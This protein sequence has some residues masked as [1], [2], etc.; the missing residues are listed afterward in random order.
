MPSKAHPDAQP[1]VVVASFENRHAAEHLLALLGREFGKQGRK[2][3]V[4]A[5]VVR[6]NKDGSL[7][8]TQSRVLTAEG[9]EGALLGFFAAVMLGLIGIVGMFKGAKTGR[10]AV[11]VHA[12]H[13]GSDEQAAHG[14]L[15]QAGPN[16]AIALVCCDDLEMRH[17]IAARARDRGAISTWDGSRS[18]FLA[19]LDPGNTHDW[20][21]AALGEPSST[22]G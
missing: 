8:L 9:L 20:V 11:H 1:S 18:E 22:T 6:G 4:T 17:T 19:N 15:A 21:R 5:F 16:A 3:H 10:H 2:G 13:V 14:I 7:N 12:G